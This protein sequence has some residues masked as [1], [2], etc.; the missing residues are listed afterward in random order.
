M[1]MLS[2]ALARNAELLTGEPLLLAASGSAADAVAGGGTGTAG[3]RGS[4]SEPTNYAHEV[5]AALEAIETARRGRRG[6]SPRAGGGDSGAAPSHAQAR[7]AVATDVDV[8]A[9]PAPPGPPS[10]PPPAGTGL[11]IWSGSLARNIAPRRPPAGAAAEGG[12]DDTS[13]S[14][15]PALPAMDVISEIEALR[16]ATL[17]MPKRSAAVRRPAP[18]P[19]A[20]SAAALGG[21]AAIG[22][23]ARL[24]AGMPSPPTATRSLAS[25]PASPTAAANPTVRI[26]AR[27]SP[28]PTVTISGASG[29]GG[30]LAAK[31]LRAA[32]ASGGAGVVVR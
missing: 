4:H 26:P 15:A 1:T 13:G 29:S 18:S 9:P 10:P 2:A 30:G 27:P 25:L 16:A 28:A 32:V 24:G 12:K 21:A 31:L 23:A 14:A 5:S 17:I 11:R 3:R 19:T 20:A 8:T 22:S 7:P 6:L